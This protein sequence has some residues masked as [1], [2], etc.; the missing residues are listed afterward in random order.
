M[1]QGNYDL[2]KMILTESNIWL[3]IFC[4]AFCQFSMWPGVKM[5][6]LRAQLRKK[7]RRAM[8]LANFYCKLAQFITIKEPCLLKKRETL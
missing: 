1:D 6:H 5:S 4:F 7:L 3:N 2:N 8:G